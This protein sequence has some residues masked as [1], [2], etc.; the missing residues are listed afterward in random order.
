[1][2]NLK[3][4]DIV[5]HSVFQFLE[6]FQIVQYWDFCYFPVVPE[7]SVFILYCNSLST[8]MYSARLCDTPIPT[9]TTLFAYFIGDPDTKQFS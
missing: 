6:L 2:L 4:K 3:G 8:L 5:F 9:C 1:M 7:Q